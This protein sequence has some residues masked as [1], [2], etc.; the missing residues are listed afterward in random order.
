[1]KDQDY[2]ETLI[3]GKIG[4]LDSAEPPEGHFE[5]FRKRLEVEHKAKT[6][7]WK[8]VWKVAATVVFIFLAVNQA[9]I[10]MAPKEI[11]P[12]T[13]ASISPEYAEVEFFYTSAVSTGLNNLNSLADAGLISLEENKMIHQEFREF[14][15]RYAA[16]QQEFNANPDDERIINA[17][18]EYYQA[19]L[20]VINLIVNKL[21]EVKQKNN[22][23]HETKI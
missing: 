23:S 3:T 16:L 18:I 10:W 2:I 1:M 19:K 14:E 20:N 17:M 13:L 21:Q 5:R 6:F 8:I 7:N 15:T 22:E 4:E 11:Q 9:R 12:V